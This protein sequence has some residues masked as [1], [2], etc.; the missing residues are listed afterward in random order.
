VYA[1]STTVHA[2]P[3]SID[4]AIAQA[5]EET[6]PAIR[7]ME[8][9]IGMSMMVDRLTGRCIVTTAWDDEDHM[10]A[11]VELVRPLRERALEITGGGRTAQ[12][13]EWEVAVMHRAHP[14]REESCVRGTWME[15][16]PSDVGRA[17]DVYRLVTMP[18]MEQM[19][20]F[21][22]ASLLVNRTT[23]KAVASTTFDSK[24]AMVATREQ[25][26]SLRAASAKEA[27]AR[28]TDVAEFELA[29]AHLHVPEMA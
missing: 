18:A 14:S 7:T 13:E 10:H 12:V 21:C 11:T 24:Q 16:L 1:R 8:G 26:A 28:V 29:L 9:C 23:G 2:K 15:I 19:P 27:D 20:G 3:E 17:L 6:L 25:A 5:R 22:S 4:A